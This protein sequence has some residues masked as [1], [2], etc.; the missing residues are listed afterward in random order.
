MHQVG[1]AAYSMH[2][3]P[4]L[5]CALLNVVS[6][7]QSINRLRPICGRTRKMPKAK[8]VHTQ[9]CRARCAIFVLK[10]VLFLYLIFCLTS[11]CPSPSS[12]FWTFLFG[13]G[14]LSSK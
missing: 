3:T 14:T 5:I 11:T 12:G 13:Y 2:G 9:R 10:K 7:R 6:D 1:T 4:F 8:Q